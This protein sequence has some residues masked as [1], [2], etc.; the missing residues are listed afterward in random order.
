MSS[1]RGKVAAGSR[2]SSSL[3][4]SGSADR[5]QAE[6]DKYVQAQAQ[7]QQERERKVAETQMRYLDALAPIALKHQA[8]MREDLAAHGRR[9]PVPP[10][11][12]EDLNDSHLYMAYMKANPTKVEKRV[13][14]PDPFHLPALHDT[15]AREKY[16]AAATK[17][18]VK[19]TDLNIEKLPVLPP[20]PNEKVR[21]VRCSGRGRVSSCLPA[22]R[23]AC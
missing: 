2:I 10:A 12:R 20:R 11:P 19:I 4:E 8:R 6:Y 21:Q 13:V 18:K 22:C 14:T 16:Q 15:V 1:G 9:V 5:A 17:K 23:P 3:K 7:R